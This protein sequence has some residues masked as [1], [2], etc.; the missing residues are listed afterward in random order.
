MSVESA[1]VTFTRAITVAAGVFAP[2][3][4]GELTRFLPFDL[5]DAVL[6][7]TGRVQQRE[8]LLPSRVVVYFMIALG[9][10]PH[11]GYTLVWGKMV[12]A[13]LPLS[14]SSPS[15]SALRQ[16][17]RRVGTT[18]LRA[19]FDVVAG[20]LARPDTPG[21]SYRGLRTVAFDGCSS[22]KSADNQ[23]QRD[24]LG[25]IRHRLGW[26]GYPQLMLMALVETGTRGLLGVR[27]GRSGPGGE[28]GYARRLLH[29]LTPDMLVLAD[30]G[31]DGNAFLAEIAAT[32][33]Q[34]LTR[35][36]SNRRPR[37]HT[38][39][40]DG[41][42][43][44]RFDDLPLRVIEATITTTAIDGTT[45]NA[46]YRLATTLLDHHTHPATTLMRLYHERWEIESAFYALKH[47]LFTGR[48][49]R[50]GSPSGLQQEL[51]ALLTLY[52]MIRAAIVEAA[53]HLPGTD[54]DRSSFTN[55]LEHARNQVINATGILPAHNEPTLIGTASGNTMPARRDRISERKVKC[56]TS[57]HAR[58]SD[59]DPRP[60]TSTPI[61]SRTYTIHTRTHTPQ[62]TTR[63]HRRKPLGPLTHTILN[64][65]KNTPDQPR[66][67]RDIAEHTNLD[68]RKARNKLHDM[69]K[70][71]Y[72]TRP[73]RGHFTASPPRATTTDQNP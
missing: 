30:R 2:G 25:K 35:I 8:R 67:I 60:A 22:F 13:L 1:T 17:R 59:N 15:E 7:E 36:T 57:R 26:A 58:K 21:V 9:M 38:S 47:T 14:L 23:A 48:V 54:P 27:F 68:Y 4:A 64:Y 73:H 63:P 43:L 69:F 71:G 41:S 31:F 66:N 32:G 53:E 65:L 10:F 40:P 44:T 56:P 28:T 39:L 20:P 5:V 19:L 55:A 16:A 11:L 29:L 34:F 42:Y 70:H 72:I 37:V 18:P 51:W 12:S 6:R 3:H 52:Q 33:A 46:R 45:I 62:P 61:T 24:W 50:S 49:L